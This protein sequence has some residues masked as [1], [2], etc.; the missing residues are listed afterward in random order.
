M[1]EHVLPADI[2]RSSF[3]II[4]SEL[5]AAGIRLP[6]RE[7][8]VILRCI[9][10][11]ADFDYVRNLYFSENAAETAVRR[12]TEGIP[13]LTDTN[14]ALSGLSKSAL[15][16]L[17]CEAHCLIAEREIAVRAEREGCTRASAA[18]EAA[19]ERWPEAARAV[20]NAPTALLKT[21]EQIENGLRPAFVV[22]VPVG[23]VNVT[24]SK[25]R[26][27]SVCREYEIP[28]IAAMGRKGGSTVAAAICNALL[29][30][31][32]DMQDPAERGWNG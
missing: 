29:Y 26:M 23:F 15:S 13:V 2:E 18:M 27:V 30:M 19:A 28:C 4:R 16:R 21:A 31:A 7:A 6:E 5:Q 3:Q 20:G 10:A 14:M 22:A 9:H 12:L 24:E 11:T 17:R 25:Q 1:A 8:P 32:A